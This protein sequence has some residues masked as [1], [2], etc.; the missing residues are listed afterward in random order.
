MKIWGTTELFLR[1]KQMTIHILRVKKGGVSSWHWHERK[2]NHFYVI[3]G[4]FQVEKINNQ[5][6][7]YTTVDLVHPGDFCIVGPG[8][9]NRHQFMAL[10]DSIVLESCYVEEGEIQEDDI[11]RLRLG[12]HT[13]FQGTVIHAP[14][15]GT[16]ETTTT[17]TAPSSSSR[18]TFSSSE[19]WQ[20]CGCQEE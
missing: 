10:E 11:H 7:R 14:D 3:S 15:D 6:G 8:V 17:A 18:W 9:E 2:Y 1:A 13:D 4:S 12:Y 5:D 19:R 16:V 20:L